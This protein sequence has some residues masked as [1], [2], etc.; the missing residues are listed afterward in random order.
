MSVT[1]MEGAPHLRTLGLRKLETI[2]VQTSYR[3][4]TQLLYI[5][6]ALSSEAK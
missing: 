2:T 3:T 5:Y 4:D 1:T 6:I